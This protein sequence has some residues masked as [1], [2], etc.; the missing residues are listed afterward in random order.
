MVDFEDY[1]VGC[2]PNMGCI[3]SLCPY[4]HVPVCTCDKCGDDVEVLY[5]YDDMELCESCLLDAMPKVRID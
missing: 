5:E 1:C 3:G 2:P 4:K